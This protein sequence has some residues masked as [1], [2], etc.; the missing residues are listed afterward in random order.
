MDS[1]SLVLILIDSLP[2]GCVLGVDLYGILGIYRKRTEAEFPMCM[3]IF[4]VYIKG[5]WRGDTD[6]FELRHNR[7]SSESQTRQQPVD[8]LFLH[9]RT[10]ERFDKTGEGQSIQVS[11]RTASNA[12]KKD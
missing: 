12:Q 2:E 9:H 1:S 7:I 10:S 6:R 5:S 8:K 11:D 4:A 3:Y